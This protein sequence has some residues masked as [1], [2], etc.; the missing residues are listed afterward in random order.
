[1]QGE[2][3]A[4]KVEIEAMIMQVETTAEN[5]LTLDDIIK[6]LSLGKNITEKSTQEKMNIVD[7]FVEKII[8]HAES[9]DI[10][11]YM[12]HFKKRRGYIGAPWGYSF[13]STF[14]F[15]GNQYER[16]A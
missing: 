8:V 12:D 6:Y 11:F 2:L 5:E 9:I 3:F 14:E 10:Y 1:M 16:F 4:L 15:M 13:V 7:T